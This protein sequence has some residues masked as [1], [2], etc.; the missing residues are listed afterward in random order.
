MADEANVFSLTKLFKAIARGHFLCDLFVISSSC[1]Y[2]ENHQAICEY[3]HVWGQ[4]LQD[5]SKREA[6]KFFSGSK[7]VE[8]RATGDDA[9]QDRLIF[10]GEFFLI[11]KLERLR[12][13]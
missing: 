11:H 6:G 13:S 9:K 7:R 12:E 1:H 5:V 10:Q 3:K 4:Q 2:D 8:S